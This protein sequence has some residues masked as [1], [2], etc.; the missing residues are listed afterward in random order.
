MLKAVQVVS[1]SYFGVFTILHLLN[2]GL[3]FLLR[4]GKDAVLLH[5]TIAVALRKYFYKNVVLETLLL[6]SLV[7]HAV[8]G[9]IDYQ[10]RNEGKPTVSFKEYLGKEYEKGTLF[11]SK[12]LHRL[13]GW[14]LT[15]LVPNHMVFT[16]VVPWLSKVSPV[17]L[18]YAI[19]GGRFLPVVFVP[20]YATLSGVGAYH[21]ASGFVRSVNYVVGKPVVKPQGMVYNAIT[22]S[23]ACAAIIGTLMAM[24]ILKYYA[25][26]DLE[27]IRMY[28]EKYPTFITKHVLTGVEEVLSGKARFAGINWGLPFQLLSGAAAT[29]VKQEM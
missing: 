15:I 18:E 22:C 7:A 29:S 19:L 3:P 6:L 8:A 21:T 1:G 28:T 14:I 20:Y 27:K 2:H 10:K 17:T 4:E 24:G 11:S 23:A 26:T 5:E 16:I 13:S 12:N 9:V 25:F